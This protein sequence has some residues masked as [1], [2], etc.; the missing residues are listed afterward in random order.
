M[1][2]FYFYLNKH[3][4]LGLSHYDTHADGS[5]VVY[6]SEKRPILNMRPGLYTFNYINDTHIIK[7]LELKNF[8]YDLTTDFELHNLGVKLLQNYKI[9]ITASHPEYYS[10]EMWNAVYEFQNN[11]LK[12]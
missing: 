9:I 5:G 8:D 6:V 1:L 2:V 12:F 11:N 4:E 7:W 10:T 3:R